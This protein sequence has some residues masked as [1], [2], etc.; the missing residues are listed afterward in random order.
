[1][2]KPCHVNLQ[3]FQEVSNPSPTTSKEHSAETTEL[4]LIGTGTLQISHPTAWHF[5]EHGTS[6][7]IEES[8]QRINITGK[9]D[10]GSLP[11]SFGWLKVASIIHEE[12]NQSEQEIEE[13]TTKKSISYLSVL[14]FH[15][16]S[17]NV[18]F[19]L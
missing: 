4:V 7:K 16:V 13:I 19:R 18:K 11:V 8:V 14:Y 15:F 10:V 5:T 12:T 6:P 3:V 9:T 1:M 17:T 2:H